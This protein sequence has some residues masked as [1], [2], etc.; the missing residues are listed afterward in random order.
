ML[1]RLDKI[2]SDAK[3]ATRS[4]SKALFRAGR[5]TVDGVPAASGAQKCDPERSLIR[6]DGEAL[7]YRE[8]YYIMM[9][10]PAGYL[11]ATED[12]RD[13]VVT[14]LLDAKL[15]ARG[16]FPAGRLD[17][18]SVG[19]LIL[20]D[21]G[22]FCHRVI[23]PKSGVIKT[24][25]ADCA[26]PIAPDAPRRFAEGL[27]LGEGLRCLPA[28]LRVSPLDP[29]RATVRLQEGKF[30][31][32]KRMLAA[33]GSPVLLLRRVSEGGLSLD[34]TLAPG[35]WRELKEGERELILL[36]GEPLNLNI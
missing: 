30:H 17:K 28:E 5:V 12:G 29:C 27:I 32:V 20:T 4:A 23:S 6:V 21:D 16:L 9:N 2:L 18:D 34:E 1:M 13:A 33:V 25:V 7:D 11:S 8:H 26:A 10:K 35:Q 15:R 36:G 31:Q 19:L 14:E 22:D 3:I 24:Y